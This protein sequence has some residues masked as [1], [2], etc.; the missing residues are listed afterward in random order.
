[1][2]SFSRVW[3]AYKPHILKYRW[4]VYGC[5]FFGTIAQIA[6]VIVAPLLYKKV[7]D[8][9]QFGYTPEVGAMIFVAFLGI[10]A[11]RIT[12]WGAWRL[13]DYVVV[14]FQT[15][16]MRDIATDTFKKLG[17]HSYEFFTHRFTGS[18]VSY[19][20]KLTRSFETLFDFVAFN[21]YVEGI[22]IVFS[23]IVLCIIAPILGI[24]FFIWVAAY[25]A[26]FYLFIHKILLLRD[27]VAHAESRTTGVLA[28]ALT[29]ILSIK[30]FAR[31]ESEH[32]Y[33]RQV[34]QEET[35][36][37]HE[38]WKYQN[39]VRGV[40]RG[41]AIAFEIVA[42]GVGLYLWTLGSITAG[43]IVLLQ[44]YLFSAFETIYNITR[45]MTRAMNALADANSMCEILEIPPSVQDNQ[46][47]EPV[48]ITDGNIDINNITF[49]YAESS[50][51]FTNFSL[52]IPA[53]QKVG[54]VGHSG[55][56][57]TTITKLLLR[58][59]DVQHGAILIDNQD[60]RSI[61]QEDLRAKIAYVPQDPLLFHRSIAENI[62]Y[63]RP[64]ATREEIIEV[65]KRA[66]AHEFIAGLKDGY[67][68]LVGERG[69]RL[70]GGERQ[71]VAIA[72]AMIKNA[73]ILILDEATSALDSISE[74]HIQAAFAELMRGKTTLV[75]AHRLSTIQS[76]D[77]IVVFEK[78]AVVEDGTHT[79]L[80]TQDGVYAELWKQQSSGFIE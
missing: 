32:T 35:D 33:Y 28:D 74:K 20:N 64:E 65:A 42:L 73:P 22:R 11:S 12:N 5:F 71:R 43:T 19:S 18:L 15:R 60:I 69:I 23:V 70:S 25:L 38:S 16:A 77:R 45:Q 56:G 48:R 44:M 24:L 79:T 57:K 8:G 80:I 62:A 6:S 51:V 59:I 50:E 34:V 66:H 30:M 75:I 3:H 49:S 67:D 47:T 68:T 78:G 72:R 61:S 52:K 27:K 17:Q 36:S 13:Y 40:Q 37:T 14:D 21:V 41:M 9:I 29:N 55:S 76:M 2:E 26:V 10:A 46:Q 54:L 63:G 1:M 53:G 31:S 39:L 58:F 4:Y 7:I